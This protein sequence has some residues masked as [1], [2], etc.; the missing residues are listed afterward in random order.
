MDPDVAS[1]EAFLNSLLL[2]SS[3]VLDS[4][5]TTQKVVLP[6]GKDLIPYIINSVSVDLFDSPAC[7]YFTNSSSPNISKEYLF[8]NVIPVNTCSNNDI[9]SNPNIPSPCSKITNQQKCSGYKMDYEIISQYN[10]EQTEYYLIQYRN[11]VGSIR[12]IIADNRAHVYNTIS[13]SSDVSLEDNDLC[14][15]ACKIFVQFISDITLSDSSKINFVFSPLIE[16]SEP[17]KTSSYLS[18]LIG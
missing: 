5:T 7:I 16:E 8:A 11:I 14:S 12:Y 2:K 17:I 3:T 4:T 13:H 10:E 15:D 6:S 9:I 18:Y 1:L